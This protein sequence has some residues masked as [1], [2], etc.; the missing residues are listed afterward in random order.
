M[1]DPDRPLSLGW[2]EA[3][4][5]EG[6]TRR[7]AKMTV[8]WPLSGKR[9]LDVGC[10]NGSYTIP[11]AA[12]FDEAYGIEIETERLED[13]RRHLTARDDAS[14]FHVQE[15]SAEKL[16]FDDEFFDVVTAIET[17]EHIVDLDQ[18]A[19]EIYRVLRPGGAFVITAPNR[20]FP[21]ET[22]SFK[23]RGREYPA[24]KWPF[25]PW[26][27]PLHRRISTARNFRPADLRTIF[28]PLGF[29]EVGIDYLMPPFERLVALQRIRPVTD[30]LEQTWFANFGVSVIGAYAK[31]AS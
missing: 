16:E 14:S 10:G 17:I 7:I 25:V 21:F 18:A 8:L 20:W 29:R 31:P 13:F 5:S 19:R 6:V 30:R 1:I 28:A 4:D 9:L 27:P 24:K 26:V 2:P 3:Y 12:G 22:H 15:M 11:M 23:I